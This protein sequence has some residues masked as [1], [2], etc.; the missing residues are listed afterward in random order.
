MT[1]SGMTYTHQ[2]KELKEFLN[3]LKLAKG[4]NCLIFAITS[5]SEVFVQQVESGGLGVIRIHLSGNINLLEDLLGW[6]KTDENTVYF[7]DGIRNQFPWILGYLNLHRDIFYDIKRPVVIFGS[8]YEITEITKYAPDLW[9]FRSRTYDFSEKKEVRGEFALVPSEPASAEYV[10][11]NLPIFDEEGEDEI[12]E[13]I[14]VDNYLLEIVKEDYKKAELYM[15]LALSYLKLQDF[16]E[17][18]EY[19]EKALRIRERLNDTFGMSIDYARLGNFYTFKKNYNEAIKYLKE[20]I[21]INP[22]D[23]EAHNNLGLLLKDLKR[24]NEAEKEYREAIQINPYLAEAHGNLGILLYNLKRFDEAEKEWREAI[25]INSD[26]AWSHYNLGILL[27][28]LKRFDEAEKEWR[29][30]IR[31]NSDF[32]EAHGNLGILLSETER[33]EEAV[34]ELET[35]R[36]L[37]EKQE[38]EADVKKMDVLLKLIR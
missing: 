13:R 29:E 24:F 25:R 38:R 14:K 33:P 6:E 31:I 2:S 18:N 15:S 8:K 34:K 26:Y 32:A 16:D 28:N 27:Y 37:F 10:H 36:E 5:N 30:A 21:R 9:R 22:D 23:A 4:A 20:A 1:V 3:E 11:Y 19:F 35:A 12:R 7:V 17:G